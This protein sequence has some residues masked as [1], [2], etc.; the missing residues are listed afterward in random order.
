MSTRRS[1]AIDGLSHL[2]AIPCATRIGPL[3][4]SSVIAPF[5]PGTREAPED[6]SDQYANVFRH[7]GLMLKEAGANWQHVAKM[8]F[9]VPDS[10]ARAPLEPF[11]LEKFPDEQSRPSRHTHIAG[12]KSIRASFIAYVED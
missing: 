4:T 9:W 5:N 7:V 10:D 12:G 3:I 11:W 1:I 2:T 6:I 8:E